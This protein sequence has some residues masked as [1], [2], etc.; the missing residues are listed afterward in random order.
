M[1]QIGSEMSDRWPKLPVNVVTTTLDLFLSRIGV[2]RNYMK[3]WWTD[4]RNNP[5]WG[6]LEISTQ[7]PILGIAAWPVLMGVG[8]QTRPLSVFMGDESRWIAEG[9]YPVLGDMLSFLLDEVPLTQ[10]DGIM[11]PD[12]IGFHYSE[13]PNTLKRRVGESPISVFKFSSPSF[14]RPQKE[15]S[16]G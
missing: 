9:N 11:Y 1:T 15:L 13:L 5:R 16:G 12:L 6:G 4:E 2:T 7:G 14:Y 3:G 10:Y 8:L